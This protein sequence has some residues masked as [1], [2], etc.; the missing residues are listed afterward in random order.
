MNEPLTP[1]QVKDYTTRADIHAPPPP[2]QPTALMVFGTNQAM[3][4]VIAAARYHQGLAP[5]IIVSGGVNRHDGVVEG[6]ELARLLHSADVPEHALRVEDQSASTPQNVQLSLP[7]LREAIATGIPL[8]AISKWYH[9]RAVYC[10]RTMLPEADPLYAIGYEPLYAANPITRDNWPD[11]PD[12]RRRVIREAEEASRRIA[13]G[14]YRPAHKTN[15][16][17]R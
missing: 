13:D 9:L 6:R 12:G 11:I 2:G 17:W 5:L 15:G 10:L 14:T 3:P 16:T 8:T 1:E 7:F 4:A